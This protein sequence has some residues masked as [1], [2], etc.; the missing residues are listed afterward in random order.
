LVSPN[1]SIFK[2]TGRG[3]NEMKKIILAF[4]LMMMASAS[5]YECYRYVN[6]SPTGTWIK[7]QASSKSEAEAYARFKGF[8]GRIDS[9][10]CH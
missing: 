9:V 5:S 10:N 6:G 4:A 7:V 8:G 1:N 2:S 3:E